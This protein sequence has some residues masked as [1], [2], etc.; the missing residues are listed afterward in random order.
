VTE[1]CK[2]SKDEANQNDMS[3]YDNICWKKCSADI[4]NI[5]NYNLTTSVSEILNSEYSDANNLCNDIC[6]AIKSADAVLPRVRYRKHVKPF[7]TSTLKNLRKAVMAARLEWMQNGSSRCLNNIYHRQYKKAK[8]NYRQEQ[9][10]AVWEFERKEFDEIAYSNELNQEKFWRLLTNRLSKKSKKGKITVLE[11]DEKV[12]SNPQVIADLWADYYEK[13]ATPTK[14]KRFDDMNT[15]VMDILQCSE[16]KQ[17][18][19]FSTPITTEEI[20]RIVKNLPNDKAP[21]IDGITYEHIKYG[22]LAVID[23]LFKLFNLIIWT[24]KIP[25][26]FK[27]AIKIPILKDNKN[28]R[29][30]DNHRGISLPLSVNKILERIVL[31]RLLRESKHG[32]HPLQGGYQKQQDAF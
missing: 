7:W 32:H 6:K 13:L 3:E 27:L 23:A 25:D 18:Y 12:Y 5:Y 22:G 15:Q 17:D 2:Q 19:I 29:S 10:R 14:D 31:S 21:G 26:C 24:E 8:C 16:F 20:N 11:K 4:L 28:S 30:F 1:N 9:R